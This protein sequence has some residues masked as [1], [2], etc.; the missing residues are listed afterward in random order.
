MAMEGSSLHRKSIAW[1]KGMLLAKAVYKATARFPADERFGLTNQLRRAAVSIPSNIAEGRGR[2]S[3]GEY[4]QFLGIARGSA[5]E[6]QTQLELASLLEFVDQAAL[7]DAEALAS[8][9]IKI[10]NAA[11]ATLRTQLS[12]KKGE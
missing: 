4:V 10:L 9:V 3:T 8:E 1:Q 6:V 2:I 7:A 5:L 11:I 12:A